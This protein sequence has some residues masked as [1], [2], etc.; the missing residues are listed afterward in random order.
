MSKND[1]NL[2]AVIFGRSPRMYFA[3][4]N[5]P[6]CFFKR[7]LSPSVRSAVKRSKV[8]LRN[9]FDNSQLPPT[10]FATIYK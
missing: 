4:S 6:Y 8:N 9:L 10:F 2:I 1:L 7:L 3:R 5:V